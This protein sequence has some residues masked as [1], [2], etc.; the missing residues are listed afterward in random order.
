MVLTAL[1]DPGTLAFLLA[2]RET[3]QAESYLR[4]SALAAPPAWKALAAIG[5]GTPCAKSPRQ[6]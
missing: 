4:S 5:R 6:E 2:N 1:G 3:R